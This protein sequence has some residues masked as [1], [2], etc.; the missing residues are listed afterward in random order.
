VAVLIAANEQAL[1]T[2]E[3]DRIVLKATASETITAEPIGKGSW[4]KTGDLLAQLDAT[5]SRNNLA[6]VEATL[7]NVKA[8]QAKKNKK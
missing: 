2:L 5:Q 4:V 8:N 6:G 7:A 3:R 1:G